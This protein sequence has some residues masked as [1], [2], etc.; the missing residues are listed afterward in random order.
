MCKACS[1]V[2]E[3]RAVQI[4]VP[5]EVAMRVGGFLI[6]INLQRRGHVGRLSCQTMR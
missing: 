2:T 4:S 1:T 5:G 6:W 3:P